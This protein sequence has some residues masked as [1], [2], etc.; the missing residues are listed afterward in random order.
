[1]TL[2]QAQGERD[3]FADLGPSLPP[4]AEVHALAAEIQVLAR[5]ASDF[6]CTGHKVD[7]PMALKQFDRIRA[8]LGPSF[9]ELR[10]SG[11]TSD[12]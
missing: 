5:R 2:R 11:E 4:R 7:L 10:T 8:L 1:M 9:D 12:G 6:S 3:A